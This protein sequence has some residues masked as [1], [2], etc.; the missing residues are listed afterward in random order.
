[1]I[2]FLLWG[3]KLLIFEKAQNVKVDL[4]QNEQAI[5]GQEK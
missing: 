2:V 5:V 3:G 4:A 1:L